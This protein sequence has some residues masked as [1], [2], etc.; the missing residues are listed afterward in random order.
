MITDETR[1]QVKKLVGEGKTGA[2]FAKALG[3]SLPGVQNIKKALGL[4]QPRKK[5]K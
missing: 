4:V 3:I 2:V 5:K 1:T